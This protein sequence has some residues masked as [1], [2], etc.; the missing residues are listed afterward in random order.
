MTGEKNGD[1]AVSDL[2]VAGSSPAAEAAVR[3]LPATCGPAPAT[4]TA[5]EQ[6]H[7]F[8]RKNR[9]GQI[10]VRVFSRAN[11]VLGAVFIA[12]AALTI[13]TMASLNYGRVPFLEAFAGAA[14]D[15]WTMITAP[16]IDRHF[17][18]AEVTEGLFV[19]LALAL[20]TTCI[21]ALVAF[22]LGLFAAANLSSRALSNAIKV[23]MS[24]CRAV[25][26]ILWVL[27]FTVAVGLGPEA[28]VCGLLFHSVAYLVKAYSESFEEIDP[29]VIEALRA[30]GASWWQIVFQS[31]LPETASSMLS[32]TFIRF[33]IN[34]VNA[35]AVGAVAGAGGIGYQL[36]LAG[37]FY[38]N[39][40]EVGFIVYYCLIVTAVLEIVATQLRKR[41]L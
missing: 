24:F 30:S 19:S 26:T 15:F 12:L 8:V 31:V 21:G 3:D 7:Q 41:Y 29:G 22:V 32:W 14:G 6:I 1:F 9:R 4:L 37:S 36:Y 28:A 39:I 27:V 35:V 5:D 13:Y 18:L 40:H 16:Y 11:A 34:F 10:R 20:L 17:S 38:H 25:P 2:P 33:E 23:V